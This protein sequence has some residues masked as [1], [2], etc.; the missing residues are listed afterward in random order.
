MNG[1]LSAGLLLR[2]SSGEQVTAGQG[3]SSSRPHSWPRPPTSSYRLLAAPSLAG[4]PSGAG[5][6]AM[7]ETQ[8]DPRST[9]V[10]YLAKLRYADGSAGDKPGTMCQEEVSGRQTNRIGGFTT[11]MEC[12]LCQVRL[13]GRP[14]RAGPG[15]MSQ[16]TR[17]LYYGS[18]NL[19]PWQT[20]PLLSL[21]REQ[22]QDA[23][24]LNR[25]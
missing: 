14:G 16:Q 6:V 5:D 22:P 23:Q 3:N 19:H 7:S 10:E 1:A 20:L 18:Q 24:P 2:S 15:R 9:V 25:L 11:L 21:R 4:N 8:R 13:H 17:P 12:S